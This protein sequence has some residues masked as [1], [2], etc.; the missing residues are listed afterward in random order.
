MW[1]AAFTNMTLE[2]TD[3]PL[4]RCSS[5]FKYN[6]QV[7]SP[8]EKTLRVI[9][10]RSYLSNTLASF[11]MFTKRLI[12]SARK[13]WSVRCFQFVNWLM[14]GIYDS[15]LCLL[16]NFYYINSY[17]Y[18]YSFCYHFILVEVLW[19]NG[20]RYCTSSLYFQILQN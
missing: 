16:M 12:L 5:K 20:Y 14:S 19:C 17:H 10:L 6:K 9:I 13:L 15:L 4:W 3:I 11:I 18:S 7:N 2:K 8:H 1:K